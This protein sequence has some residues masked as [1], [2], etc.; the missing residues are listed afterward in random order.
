MPKL[1]KGGG[2]TFSSGLPVNFLNL[3]TLFRSYF[4][5]IIYIFLGCYVSYF[6]VNY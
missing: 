4:D 5:A 1:E 3:Y 6:V 2:F